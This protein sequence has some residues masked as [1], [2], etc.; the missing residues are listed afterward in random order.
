M[1]K[2]KTMRDMNG[3][4]TYIC[5][6]MMDSR[7]HYPRNRVHTV[8]RLADSPDNRV[9]SSRIVEVETE[10]ASFMAENRYDILVASHPAEVGDHL[11]FLLNFGSVHSN[12]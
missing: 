2:T 7:G 12:K 4:R 6:A 8:Y 5:F 9:K 3:D 1:H 10:L 11:Y